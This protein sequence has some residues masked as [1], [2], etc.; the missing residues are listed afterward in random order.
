MGYEVME[1]YVIGNETK[2]QRQDPS[3]P[4]QTYQLP[5]NAKIIGAEA[6]REMGELLESSMQLDLQ[7]PKDLKTFAQN[8]CNFC[9]NPEFAITTSEECVGYNDSPT[10]RDFSPL[11]SGPITALRI[12]LSGEDGITK[13]SLENCHKLFGEKW[14]IKAVQTLF[15]APISI[16]IREQLLIA[17]EQYYK[18][19]HRFG[20]PSDLQ[21]TVFNP[22]LR[23]LFEKRDKII[24]KL[25]NSE[26]PEANAIKQADDQLQGEWQNYLKSYTSPTKTTFEDLQAFRE[27][28]KLN[29]DVLV[30]SEGKSLHEAE[31]IVDSQLESDGEY[32]QF[33]RAHPEI[34]P[35]AVK[36]DPDVGRHEGVTL[37][38]GHM[39]IMVNSDHEHQ[40]TLKAI[41][42]L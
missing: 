35:D 6:Y 5:D 33:L 8:L 26:M 15:K 38:I 30:R 4:Y 23:S 7:N 11:L 3:A 41:L 28:R 36:V 25:K 12:L 24:K 20:K 42:G 9:S 40:L 17:Y 27:I 29:I 18:E 14:V 2:R 16:S 22:D 32:Q 37:D 21:K 10:P 31:Q 34:G 1:G 13:E 39:R 19:H